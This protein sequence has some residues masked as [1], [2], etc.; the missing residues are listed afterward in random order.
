MNKV[1]VLLITIS[2]LANLLLA[3]YLA[4]ANT[5][6]LNHNGKVEIRD[7]SILTKNWTK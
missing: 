2:L 5:G 4:Q 7:L 1:L 3:F 6:D